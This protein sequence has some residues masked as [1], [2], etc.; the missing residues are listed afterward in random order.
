MDGWMEGWDCSFLFNSCMVVPHPHEATNGALIAEVRLCYT[1]S[2]LLLCWRRCL[3]LRLRG[4][5][6]KLSFPFMILSPVG[7]G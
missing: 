2:Y 3:V 4:R 7:L 6:V 5:W 1:C